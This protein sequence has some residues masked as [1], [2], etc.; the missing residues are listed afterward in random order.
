[1]EAPFVTET[2]LQRV[3][4]LADQIAS[5][6][7]SLAAAAGYSAEARAKLVSNGILG[8]KFKATRI[9]RPARFGPGEDLDVRE[10]SGGL[11]GV[12]EEDDFIEPLRLEE[13]DRWLYEI[14]LPHLVDAIREDNGIDGAR[15]KLSR[16][17]RRLP[18]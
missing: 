16:V 1:M 2:L 14:S 13:D 3:L 9:P 18:A 17:L 5:P 12:A 15:R 11:L 7:I 4:F 6:A 10:T 8:R